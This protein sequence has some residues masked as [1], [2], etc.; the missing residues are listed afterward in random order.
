MVVCL[1]TISFHNHKAISTTLARKKGKKF[2]SQSSPKNRGFH[3]HK[4][5]SFP[6]RSLSTGKQFITK[7]AIAVY[8][9]ITEFW[10][11]LIGT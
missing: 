10:N 7:K 11:V 4:I 8:K 5:R 2:F 6:R 9:S 1:K 3:D